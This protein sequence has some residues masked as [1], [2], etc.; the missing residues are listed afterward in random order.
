MKRHNEPKV[1]I[2]KSIGWGGGV[3]TPEW[4]LQRLLPYRLATPQRRLDKSSNL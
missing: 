2:P 1:I 4:K 3:R